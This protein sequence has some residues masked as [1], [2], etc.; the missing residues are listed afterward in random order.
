MPGW[1]RIYLGDRCTLVNLWGSFAG[2]LS[3]CRSF[4]RDAGKSI[5]GRRSWLVSGAGGGGSSVVA[6]KRVLNLADGKLN[7]PHALRADEE[8]SWR[9]FDGVVSWSVGRR[10][11]SCNRGG[12][13]FPSWR[14]NFLLVTSP[15]EGVYVQ[16]STLHM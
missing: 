5:L 16:N 9:H 13:L 14:F 3:S 15:V 10:S 7:Y 8:C 6:E 4:L 1:R 12:F 2:D 11:S